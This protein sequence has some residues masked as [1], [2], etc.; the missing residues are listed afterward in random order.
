MNVSQKTA[1]IDDLMSGSE[2][3]ETLRDDRAVYL[4]GERVQ[5]VT[6]H[7]AFR[8]SARSIARLYD[9]LHKEEWRDLMTTVDR[10]GI[11][12]HRFFAPS[13]SAV[14]LLAARDAIAAWARLTYGFMGRTPDYK[15]AF[16][17]TLGANPEFYSPFE[18]NA[19]QWYRRFASKALYLNHVLINPP[20]DR[21]KPVHE[22]ADVFLHV[23]RET[24]RGAI[25]SG[26]KM[27]ATGSALTNATFV[28]QNSATTLQQGKAEDFALVFI[29][30]M[31]TPGT[32]LLCRPSYEQSARSPFDQPLSS[33]FD[34]NDAVLIFDGAL[35]PW[36]NFL[37]Y[38]NVERANSFFPESGFFNRYNLQG[39]TRLAVKLDLMTG[40]LARGLAIN[41]TD[42]FR[43][44]QAALGD[45]IAWRTLM[46]AMTTALASDPQ[47]GPGGSVVP[48]LEYA[49]AM[50]IFATSAWPAVKN[51]MENVLGGA[52]LVTASGPEDLQNPDLRPLIDR[53]YRGTNSSAEDRIKL[54]KLIW[55]AIGTEFAGRHELYERNYAGN[56]EQIR[57]DAVNFAKRSGALDAC[58]KL[59]DECLADYDLDG[60]RN[61]TW[62]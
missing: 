20:V 36:E 24:D 8:N 18:E 45:V 56:H 12:T 13:Y 33:R 35:I 28:A 48:R 47:P 2:Y 46:W 29:A 21:M 62:L 30:P 58:L 57:V 19:R 25:V 6:V 42:G 3:L 40:L 31:D 4:Y 43:G 41:G 49:A 7:P 17:A 39:G 52:P 61:D 27:L 1:V 50:R 26:A 5:D 16:M 53:Y 60:W 38:R 9:A 32:K 54:F 51:I 22:I 55:D 59:V 10:F 23:V 44:V 34:E 37:V 15:A 11:R 14:E